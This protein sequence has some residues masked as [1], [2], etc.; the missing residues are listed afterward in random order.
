MLLELGS[1]REDLFQYAWMLEPTGKGK[2]IVV[3]HVIKLQ[4]AVSSSLKK[5][6]GGKGT[7]GGETKEKMALVQHCRTGYNVV[8][9][10]LSFSTTSFIWE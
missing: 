2:M 5:G 1:I 10:E 9:S 6:G 7:G 4:D 8:S 3:S